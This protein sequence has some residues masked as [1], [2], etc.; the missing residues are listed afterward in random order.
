M[1]SDSAGVWQET[2]L[3]C[4]VCGKYKMEGKLNSV[5]GKL[6]LRCQS[7]FKET[8][9]LFN[10]T[11][12]LP[13]VIGEVNGFK[14]AFNRISR[15]ANDFYLPGLRAGVT[16]CSSCGRP[17]KTT[18]VDSGDHTHY[19]IDASCQ[20]CA[21]MNYTTLD[22]AAFSL[23]ESQR[24]WQQYPRLRQL[25]LQHIAEV[26]GQPGILIIQESV[27]TGKQLQCLFGLHSYHFLSIE[28]K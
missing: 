5:V 12:T 24:F 21:C 20:Q 18:W 22:G 6:Y 10:A 19:K 7:C 9:D 28:E 27:E 15:W 26:E 11:D 23:P 4:P 2:S 16:A 8:G 1:G 25:P 3:W 13:Q 17:V 14:P